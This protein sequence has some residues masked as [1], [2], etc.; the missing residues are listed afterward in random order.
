MFEMWRKAIGVLVGVLIDIPI[1]VF[2]TYLLSLIQDNTILYISGHVVL[3]ISLV[4][5]PFSFALLFS[6]KPN[7]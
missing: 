1:F 2:I 7:V 5:I 6:S 4:S 3:A